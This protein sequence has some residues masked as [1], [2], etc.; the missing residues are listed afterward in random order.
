MLKD[1]VE[2]RGTYF[3][4]YTFHGFQILHKLFEIIAYFI[5][6]LYKECEIYRIYV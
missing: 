1:D 4:I 3:I 6:N 5:Y 2:F